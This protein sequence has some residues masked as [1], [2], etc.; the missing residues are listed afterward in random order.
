M[1]RKVESNIL[2]PLF[3]LVEHNRIYLG[4]CKSNCGLILLKFAIWYWNTFL[5]KC[6]YVIYHFNVH[7]SLFFANELLL[8]AY[9]ILF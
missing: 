9:L 6:D 5:N 1:I 4:W 8:A 3:L 2:T 7:V